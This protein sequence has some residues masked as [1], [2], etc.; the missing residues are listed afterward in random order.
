MQTDPFLVALW[1]GALSAAAHG[2]AAY[3]D[4]ALSVLV[5]ECLKHYQA[6]ARA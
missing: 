2:H 3:L 6:H 4:H 1:I 5:D